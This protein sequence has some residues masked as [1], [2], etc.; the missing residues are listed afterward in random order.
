MSVRPS[1]VH[2]CSVVCDVMWCDSCH[3]RLPPSRLQAS[4]LLQWWYSCL[5]TVHLHRNFFLSSNDRSSWNTVQNIRTA[6][7][8]AEKPFLYSVFCNSSQCNVQF[9]NATH[10]Y[11][12]N[13]F[14][15]LY[16]L[17][18]CLPIGFQLDLL[19]VGAVFT[20]QMLFLAHKQQ[21]QRTTR[22]LFDTLFN[23]LVSTET[24]LVNN[25]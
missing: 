3:R 8:S 9:S 4:F 6:G 11:F 1:S 14:P 15:G 21:C 25:W 13:R 2:R 22:K 10:Y 16:G 12:I 24:K 20:G 23:Q 18:G 7:W 17:A 19:S 5:V